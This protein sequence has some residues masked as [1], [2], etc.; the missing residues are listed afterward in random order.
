MFIL[1]QIAGTQAPL[2]ASCKCL[3]DYIVVL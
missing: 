2:T 3:L 1:Q